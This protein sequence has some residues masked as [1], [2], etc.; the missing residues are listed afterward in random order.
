MSETGNIIDQFY[1][2]FAKRDWQTMQSCYH[3]KATFSDPVFQNLSA[4]ETKA[5]WHMLTT[6][7]KELSITFDSVKTKGDEAT[8][9]WEAVYPFSRTGRKVHNKITAKFT[10]KDGKILKHQD[11]FDLWKWS[12]MA[13]GI[14]GL[15]LGWSPFIQNK[16]RNTAKKGLEKF[17][18]EHADYQ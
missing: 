17:I 13:L 1:T 2:A 10:F 12:R 7:A 4:K 18:R 14:S 3:D 9:H 16:I 11:S 6:S 5:M 8:C 15:L